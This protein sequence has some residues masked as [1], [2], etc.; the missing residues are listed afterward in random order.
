MKCPD[1]KLRMKYMCGGS[2]FDRNC[3]VVQ[4]PKTYYKC[5][6]CG[7]IESEDNP[8]CKYADKEQLKEEK[9]F[10][11]QVRKDVKEE[12]RKRKEK[13]NGI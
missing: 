10:M 2:G 7:R 9:E 11:K 5:L 3:G 6:K 1:C 4:Y 13:E 12:K 8:Y